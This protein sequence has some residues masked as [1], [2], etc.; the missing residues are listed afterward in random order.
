MRRTKI[1]CTIGPVTDSEE[2]L[3][4]LIEAGMNVARLNFSHGTHDE[5]LQTLR[6][7]RNVAEK[8]GQPIAILQ[9]LAGPKLR[10]G[11]F[12]KEPV[13]LKA[14]QTF[15]LTIDDVPGDETRA[16][17]SIPELTND[18]KPGDR[19]LLAD[20]SIELLVEKTD[21]KNVICK[22]KV[23]GPL[24][25]HKGVNLPG[26]S[27]SVK[28]FTDKDRADLEFGLE[29][30]VDYVA[31]S[32]VRRKEDILEVKEIMESKSQRVPIVAKIE[33]YE[34]L[35]NISEIIEA[36]DGIMVARGD[37][38]VE[39]ALER[40]PLAQKMIIKLCNEASK[41]VITATQMLKSMVDNPRPTRAEANDVANAV[42]DG[43]DA[44][45]LSE[46]TTVGNYPI[47]AVKTMANIIEVTES[48]KVAELNRRRRETSEVTG[49]AQAVSHASYQMAR[50][51]NA[52]VI[53]TPTQSGGTARMVSSFRPSQPIIA[54][55]PIPEVVRRLNLVWG[56]YPIV[57]GT[58]QNT[59]EMMEEA[60]D[61]A[62]K[63]GLAKIGDK[64]VITAGVPVG[65]AGTTNLIKA[66]TIW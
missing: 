55:S 22:V 23:G 10:V 17:V 32:F 4:Q 36:A 42:L 46:E 12:K 1:V 56:V 45:M 35:E 24:S 18:V 3:G 43:T 62:L 59:D 34:A 52:A 11:K 48:S 44:V 47:E 57:S 49:I 54:F 7:I 33:K 28:A 20:G 13:I 51:L 14:G 64:V 66:E 25:S 37:L 40:V 30:G 2:M 63:S 26:I 50:D 15:T 19:I 6:R 61:K 27:L 21:A 9:D 38:A 5:H 65:V 8:K 53:I 16:A 29:H 41:P 58:F 31:M 39:T 60:I